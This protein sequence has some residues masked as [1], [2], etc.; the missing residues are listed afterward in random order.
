MGIGLVNDGPAESHR[1]LSGLQAMVLQRSTWFAS[2]G[3]T[4]SR[5]RDD[6]RVAR[7][8]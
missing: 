2:D 4:E 6:G 1:G 5:G 3:F 7:K 8:R